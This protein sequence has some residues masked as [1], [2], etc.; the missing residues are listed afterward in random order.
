MQK[1]QPLLRT[2]S[3]L[4]SIYG[5]LAF[6]ALGRSIFELLFKFSDAPVPYSLS[7]FSAAVYVVATIAL[8][9]NTKTSSKVALVAVAVEMAGV[10][11]V[12]AASLFEP[13][14]FTFESKQI[15]T[16]WSYF[17]VAYGF[18]PLVLPFVGWFWLR[19]HLAK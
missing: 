17:G 5:I 6:A 9:R 11:L 2:G 4:V 12:G 15:H 16:V 1:N 7:T 13:A 18:I 8:A 3:V 19:R 10:L 14:W